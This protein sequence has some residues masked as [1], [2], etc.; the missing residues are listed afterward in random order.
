MKIASLL[1]AGVIA[2][3]L[4]SF[5]GSNDE[6]EVKYVLNTGKS[7]LKW[8][9]GKSEN[10]FHVGTV[11][12]KHGKV[13]MENGMLKEGEFEVDLGSI[14]VTD[15]QMPEEKRKKLAGHLQTE[16]FFNVAKYATADVEVEGYHDGKLHT[17]ITVLGVPVT[18]D[19]PVKL[20]N[21]DKG[22]TI[23]GTFDYDFTAANIPGTQL[24][25]GETER[26]SPVFHYDLHLELKK[27]EK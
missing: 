10:Y 13:E 25:E 4:V 1:V 16:D 14:K 2:T 15:M 22:L 12:F 18:Q 9:A 8:K 5:N 21:T 26:I 17:T 6:K 27:A 23:E 7:S 24:H 20:I 19:V 3:A 11:D